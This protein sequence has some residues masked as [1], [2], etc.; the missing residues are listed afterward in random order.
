MAYNSDSRSS[1]GNNTGALN[2]LRMRYGESLTPK[3]TNEPHMNIDCITCSRTCGSKQKFI[4][5]KCKLICGI[6]EKNHIITR[7]RRVG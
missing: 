7:K 6:N 2:M 4:K 1:Y 5:D 3:S